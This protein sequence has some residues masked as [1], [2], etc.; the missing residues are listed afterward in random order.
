MTRTRQPGIDAEV[1]R[2][3]AILASLATAQSSAIRITPETRAD[4]AYEVALNIARSQGATSANGLELARR[5][6]TRI[7]WQ[8]LN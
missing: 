8:A 7:L 1:D 4:V 6:R 2:I 3:V 5:V